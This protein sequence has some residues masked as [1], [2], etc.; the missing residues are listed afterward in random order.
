M[1]LNLSG[2][3]QKDVFD[4]QVASVI[5]DIRADICHNTTIQK[6]IRYKR[7]CCIQFMEYIEYTVELF[8]AKYQCADLV[9]FFSHSTINSR[10]T[11]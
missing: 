3:F 11:C 2:G 6:D 7:K 8:K 4:T 9:S 1:Q 10:V 5:S